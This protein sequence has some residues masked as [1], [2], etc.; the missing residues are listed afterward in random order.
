[1][2]RIVVVSPPFQSHAR[3]LSVLAGALRRAGDEVHFACAPAFEELARE[4]D[5][6]FVPL[7]VT[8]NA[9]TGI[10]ETTEQDTAEAARL[11]EF[12]DATRA[13]AVPALLAQARHRGADMLADPERILADLR[14]L[15]DRLRPDWY[16]VDQLNYP[17]TLAL[18]CL[19]LSYASYCP[20]HPGYLPAGPDAFFGEPC[21]WPAGIRPRPA[22]R[23]ALRTAVRANDAAFTSLFADFAALHAPHR[24][25]PGRAFALTSPHAVV[26]CYPPLPGLP[27]PPE[28]RE[29][30]YAGHCTAQDAPVLD[31]YWRGA[32]DRLRAAAGKVVL[33]AFGTFLSARDDVL[34]TVARGVLERCPDAAV[35]LAAG[36]RTAAVADLA[37]PRVCVAASVPQRALLAEVDAM[38]HHGG[39]NSF[40]ECVAAG[41]PALVLP[42]SSD[43][44][45]VAHD[46]ERAG[47]ALVLDPAAATGREIGDAVAS[48][49]TAPPPGLGRLS[50]RVCERGPDW[51]AVRLRAV[52]AA[53]QER[54]VAP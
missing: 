20:G 1:M 49:L 50:A 29:A 23:A 24:P 2:A 4:A 14:I 34:R 22:E 42:F 16:L 9:N 3:P 19:G 11:T 25:P 46:A 44:F 32:A 52:M 7:T 30:L 54:P 47:A 37:G 21:A 12:L 36:D 28:G 39:N 13:G 35:V 10:A 38:V 31:P 43:Q 17:V 5:I 26:Y 53:R 18:H 48:L 40:T 51:A 8:R 27:V 6:G 15:H 45:A 41:V 33:V